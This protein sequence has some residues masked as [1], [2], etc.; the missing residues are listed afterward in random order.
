MA[1]GEPLSL[2][3]AVGRALAYAPAIDTA[4]AGVER[5]RAGIEAARARRGVQ[6]GVQGQI[7]VLETDFT[8]DSISQNPRSVGLQAEWPV[9]ASGALGAAVDAARSMEES[10]AQSLLSAREATVLS[11]VEAFAR[12][13]LAQRV[14]DV[15][16]ARV[17]TF[18]IR[19]DETNS[20]FEQGLVTRT[21]IA[22]TEAR[23]ASS[24]AALESSRANLAGALARLE[25]LTGIAEIDPESPFAANLM[26]PGSYAETLA[27]VLEANP[28]LAAAR[29]AQEAASHRLNEARGQF[30][31]KVSLKARASTGEDIYFF[32]PDPITDVGAFVTVEIPLFTSGLKAASE[33]EARAGRNEAN[34]SAR[35]AELGLRE[36]VSG[37]WGDLEARKLALDAAQR[38]EDAAELAAEG[39]QKEYEA[40]VRT[41]VDALDAENA[42]RDAQ[43][44]R[45]QAETSLLIVQARLL[46]LSSDLEAR[47][48]SDV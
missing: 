48:A 13:W 4:Q 41:L 15:G 29:S 44:Q 33:R 18:R 39:A 43:I 9:Y 23:Y 22:L 12:V 37:L 31:P 47:L 11:T 42:F 28:D 34:A 45:Y 24:Q 19:L 16:A 17:G 7:G 32:F 40:G 14:V 35:T 3:D 25:R 1:A 21:D 27:N 2:R 20:R 46:S 6:A 10:A 30:G 26:I 36:A 8:T 5:S 38:A